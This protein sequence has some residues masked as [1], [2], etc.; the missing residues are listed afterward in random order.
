MNKIT[1]LTKKLEIEYEDLNEY[2][3]HMTLSD[4]FDSV[5]CGAFIDDDGYGYLSTQDKESSIR[6]YPSESKSRTIG[7]VWCEFFY[8]FD[9]KYIPKE[10]MDKFTHI[11]WYNR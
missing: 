8:E 11:S 5:E 4:Y 2:S 3:D 10:I 9:S 7:K 6:I 1:V